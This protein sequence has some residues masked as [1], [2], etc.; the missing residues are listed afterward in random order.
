MSDLP[1]SKLGPGGQEVEILFVHH[2]SGQECV[3]SPMEVLKVVVRALDSVVGG[4]EDA[5]RARETL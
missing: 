3:G 4:D 2:A 1:H 5:V